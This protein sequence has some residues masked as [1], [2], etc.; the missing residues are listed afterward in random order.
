MP[1]SEFFALVQES[2]FGT[3][4]A[5]PVNGT[6]RHYLRL[7]ADDSYK[8]LMKPVIE[9]V[10]TG[11]SVSFPACA[12]SDSSVYEG[13]IQSEL[14]P[15]QAK[16]LLDW[17]CTRINAGRT[18][19]WVTTDAA[20]LNPPGD[21][22]SASAY[23]A[24]RELDGM[25]TRR[26]GAGC[27]VKTLNLSCSGSSRIWRWNATFVGIRDDT[28]GDGTIGAPDATEFPEPDADDYPCGPYLFSHTS[29]GLKIGTVRSL[30]DSVQLSIQNAVA[31]YA[32][33]SP[34]PQVIWFGGRT[35]TLQVAMLRRPG[36][37]DLAAFRA[38]TALDVELALF[39]GKNTLTIDLQSAVRWSDFDQQLPVGSP[40]K[41]AG[42]LKCYIDRTSGDDIAVSYSSV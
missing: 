25:I 40:Y 16:F 34:V 19:P 26:R 3:P 17:A 15:S 29:G 7:A 14:Y 13:S 9:D 31:P 12:V 39:D 28:K 8:G 41:W 38:L 21:L 42:T 32:S 4:V 35:V 11:G 20:A 27:K 37:T 5:E 18:T 36:A 1:S 6:S 23:H 33:E 30:F 10:P 2:S 22:A 24:A